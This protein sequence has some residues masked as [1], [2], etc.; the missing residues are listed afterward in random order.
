MNL[1]LGVDTGGTYTDSVIIDFSSGEVLAKAKALTTRQDLSVGIAN[2]VDNLGKIHSNQIRLVSVSTTLAT[3]SI[4]EGKG[5]RACLLGIGYDRKT[6]YKH[7]L[8]DAFP[9][10]EVRL[11][12]GGHDI[13]GQEIRPLDIQCLRRVTKL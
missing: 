10:K 3:N 7:G 13:S 8:G 4:V 12:P 5:A 1:G 9:V 11:I 6:L 2:S